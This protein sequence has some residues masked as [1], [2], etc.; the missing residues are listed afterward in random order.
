MQG[1]ITLVG[2][3]FPLYKGIITRLAYYQGNFSYY[4]GNFPLQGEISLCYWEFYFYTGIGP[5]NT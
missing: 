5:Q 3:N 4:T 2:G 1:K